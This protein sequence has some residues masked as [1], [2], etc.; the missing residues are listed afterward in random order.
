MSN[1]LAVQGRTSYGNVLKMIADDSSGKQDFKTPMSNLYMDADGDISFFN[2]SRVDGN[3]FKDL[4]FSST[5]WAESQIYG[6]LG[7]PA[8]Y[9]KKL[10][11]EE[12]ALLQDHFNYWAHKSD[13]DILLRTKIKGNDRGLIRGVVSDQYSIMDNDMVG[14]MLKSIL[15][16]NEDRFSI[17]GFSITDR[18][19]HLRLT[20]VDATQ[21]IGYLKDGSPDY[22]Q[23]G[24]D[25]VNSEVGYS[26]YNMMGLVYRLICSNGMRRWMPNGETFAQRHIFLKTYEFQA[27]IALALVS[28]YKQGEDMFRNLQGTI[29][30]KIENPFR[31]IERLSAKG[32]MSKDFTDIAKND[33]EGDNTAYSVIN[34]I[35]SAAKSLPSERRL[36]V[37]RFAGGLP[38]FN[39]SEWER[40]DFNE[41][42]ETASESAEF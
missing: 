9:F 27:R 37:E 36:D 18:I 22:L 15:S 26:S 32:G 3:G 41:D 24:S 30:Q 20:F 16:G 39:T 10:R 1:T 2:T 21:T 13:N 11:S 7:M 14:D 29:Q 25:I 12:P 5:D 23:I 17:Q 6:K 42:V 33:W 28:N 40:V 38:Y 35:T 4:T 19:M 31:V 8:Q 34:S